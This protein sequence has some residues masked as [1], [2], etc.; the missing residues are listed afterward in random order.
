[1]EG[2]F[3]KTVK[4]FIFETLISNFQIFHKLPTKRVD[5]GQLKGGSLHKGA[6]LQTVSR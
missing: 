2:F 4:W 6:S 1:M 3:Y 5:R